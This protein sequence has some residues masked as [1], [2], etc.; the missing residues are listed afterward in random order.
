LISRSCLKRNVKDF[1]ITPKICP[2]V[3]HGAQ[4]HSLQGLHIANLAFEH[5]HNFVAHGFLARLAE[6]NLDLV[7]GL[8]DLLHKGGLF[9][10]RGRCNGIFSIQ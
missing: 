4:L 3:S 2:A 6:M 5:T 10:L 9:G 7:G 8:A 1:F